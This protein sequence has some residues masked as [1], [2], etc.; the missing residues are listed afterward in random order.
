[1]D[2]QEVMEYVSTDGILTIPLA[3][4]GAEKRPLPTLEVELREDD[5]C[6]ALVYRNANSLRHLKNLLHP[7]QTAS[8]GAFTDSMKM[9]PVLFETLLLKRGF[10]E[11]DYSLVK[12]YVASRVDTPMLSLLIEEAE[13]IR[14]GGR[15]TYDGGSVYEAPATPVLCLLYKQQ[16]SSEADLRETLVNMNPIILLITG[17]KTQREI[18][19]SRLSKPV[20]EAK[21][22]RE[23]IELI[24]KARS[25]DIISAEERRSLE[26][27]WR[28]VPEERGPIE[29]D[30]KRRINP[31]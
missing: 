29:E 20:N 15:K 7:T 22:Y 13:T 2:N 8:Q 4:Q 6:I 5:L 17:V 19:H 1:L 21:K 10:K 12:K 23:F 9:L 25:I 26:K 30:L 27:R 24:N 28:E 16:K 11:S 18:I 31:T 3:E 14:S